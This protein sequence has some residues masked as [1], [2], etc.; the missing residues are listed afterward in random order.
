M[1]RKKWYIEFDAILGFG[2]PL[3][4]L[5][6]FSLGSE[7][8]STIEIKRC[9]KLIAKKKEKYLNAFLHSIYFH[10]YKKQLLINISEYKNKSR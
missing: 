10:S 6:H 9:S 3:G 8:H 4:V 1:Y 2:C 7:A 5:E